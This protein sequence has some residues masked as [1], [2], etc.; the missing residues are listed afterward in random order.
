MDEPTV[1]RGLLDLTSCIQHVTGKKC[2]VLIDDMDK[3]LLPEGDTIQLAEQSAEVGH[4]TMI[5]LSLNL[6]LQIN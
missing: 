3:A 4:L 1:L 6:K 5:I 2:I